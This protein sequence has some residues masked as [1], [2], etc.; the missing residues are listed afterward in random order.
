M[1]SAITCV[2]LTTL[3]SDA[4][5]SIGLLGSLSHILDHPCQTLGCNFNPRGRREVYGGSIEISDCR[6]STSLTSP[7]PLLQ[8]ECM[9]QLLLHHLPSHLPHPP[10]PPPSLHPP[11]YSR[12]PRSPPLFIPLERLTQH[13]PVPPPASS[14]LSYPLHRSPLLLPS[15]LV[16]A[17][18]PPLPQPSAVD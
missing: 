17:H 2:Y 5:S 18:T 11:L 16:S 14:P 7:P 10:S 9:L 4:L 6:T 12:L 8:T 15:L 13:T 3:S 1:E